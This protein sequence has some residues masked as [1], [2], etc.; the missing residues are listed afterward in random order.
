MFT[1][2]FQKIQHCCHLSSQSLTN[3]KKTCSQS[4]YMTYQ[5]KHLDRNGKRTQRRVS[6]Q[7][8]NWMLP[9][10]TPPS[11]KTK[12]KRVLNFLQKAVTLSQRARQ[13][14]PF[15]AK[16]SFRRR[17]WIINHVKCRIQRRWMFLFQRHFHHYRNVAPVFSRCLY[18]STSNLAKQPQR[19]RSRAIL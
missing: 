6:F 7:L 3:P 1:F 17:Q 4:S 19:L 10:I 12:K 9:N 16:R 15:P 5:K 14:W 2:L 13:T 18:R 11:N 8:L